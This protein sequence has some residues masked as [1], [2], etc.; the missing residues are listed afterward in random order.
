[1]IKTDYYQWLVEK[2]GLNPG[3]YSSL[4][5]ALYY[6]PFRWSG[7]IRTDSNRAKDGL[8]LR[9][10]YQAE[11]GLLPFVKGDCSVLEMLVA[12][13][14]R[15]DDVLGTPGET[16]IDEWFQIMVGNLGLLE[17]T[18]DYFSGYEVESTIDRWLDR[19]F[20]Y[21]GKGGIFPMV[22][23]PEDQREIPLWDQM[24][25]YFNPYN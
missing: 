20:S 4:L 14:I 10:D 25:C 17:E 8:V 2:T 18:N 15:I 12:L 24:A 3:E 1:M 23:S 22:N 5:S 13:A 19:D 11:T 21:N 16:H 6:I 7:N 9:C